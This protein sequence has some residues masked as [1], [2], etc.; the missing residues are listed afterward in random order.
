MAAGE[1]FDGLLASLLLVVEGAAI[2][3]ESQFFG[4][5]AAGLTEEILQLALEDG[6]LAAERSLLVGVLGEAAGEFDFAGIEMI[7]GVAEI[8]L[9]LLEGFGLFGAGI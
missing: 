9:G 7:D 6:Q 3:E 4:F 2:F 5:E 8:V 1:L